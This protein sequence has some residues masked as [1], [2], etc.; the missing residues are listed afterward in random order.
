MINEEI[1]YNYVENHRNIKE[2]EIVNIIYY[3][4]PVSIT[5]KQIKN[6]LAHLV[7]ENRLIIQENNGSRKYSINTTQIM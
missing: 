2:E 6:I 7:N 3:D 4:S 5:K 1:I